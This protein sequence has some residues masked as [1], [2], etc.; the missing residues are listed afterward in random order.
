MLLVLLACTDELKSDIQSTDGR[1][2]QADA[3]IAALRSD[4]AAVQARLEQAEMTL[5]VVHRA[6][7]DAEARLATCE[8]GVAALEADASALHTT[9][10]EISTTVS[11]LG[12][13]VA[14][15]DDRFLDVETR[16][17]FVDAEFEALEATDGVCAS[18]LAEL[19]SSVEDLADQVT[20]RA[21]AFSLPYWYASDAPTGGD[22]VLSTE[23]W[24]TLFDPLDITLDSGGALLVQCSLDTSDDYGA[25]R[26]AIE[27]ADG[28]WSD[29]STP[30]NSGYSGSTGEDGWVASAIFQAPAAGDYDVACEGSASSNANGYAL[31][32]VQLAATP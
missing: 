14:D 2:D 6:Y 31:W 11:T 17:G 24:G 5:E 29:A 28:S 20:T 27:A 26:V 32:A 19:T 9:D 23:T 1:V 21:T 4:L 18:E 30:L 8:F 15:H 12:A 16:L 13:E 7:E 3:D 25:F 22:G 10:A